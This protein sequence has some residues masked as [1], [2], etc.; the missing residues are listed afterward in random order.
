MHCSENSY[1]I[2][3]K[4]K[5]NTAFILGFSSSTN[6]FEI[7]VRDSVKIS[8]V[9]GNWNI[10]NDN[11]SVMP[12]TFGVQEWTCL[13]CGLGHNVENCDWPYFTM[14]CSHC[15][16]VSTDGNGHQ[17]PC[18]FKNRITNLR[19]DILAEIPLRLFELRVETSQAKL[20]FLNVKS[21]RFEEPSNKTKLVTSA[22]EGLLQFEKTDSY[23]YVRFDAIY[24]SRISLLFAIF[25]DTFWRLRFSATVTHKHGLMV[26]KLTRT[27]QCVNTVFQIPVIRGSNPIGIIGLVP[28]IQTDGSRQC[29]I[30]FKIY[31]NEN[32]YISDD[33][34][35]GYT[36]HIDWNMNRN[37]EQYEISDCLNGNIENSFNKSLIRKE[38]PQ[39]GRFYDGRVAPMPFDGPR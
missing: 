26:F 33:P 2:P 32:G 16:V 29:T 13:N 6:E 20:L 27:M 28:E 37:F 14:H 21:G 1:A 24:L 36:G 23:Q 4:I 30:E 39:L 8:F 38:P 10:P 9:N 18:N 15:F 3:D 17:Y 35:N 25:Q 7:E 12:Y 22:A 5:L 19:D 11:E 31:A 34:F